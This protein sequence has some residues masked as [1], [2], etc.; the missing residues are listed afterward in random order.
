MS[1]LPLCFH[2]LADFIVIG[3]RRS[4]EQRVGKGDTHLYTV[5]IL[6]PDVGSLLFGR[7]QDIDVWVRI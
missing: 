2:R 5:I 1:S 7:A 6:R 4:G 3:K